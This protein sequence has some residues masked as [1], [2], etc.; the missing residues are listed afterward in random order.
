MKYIIIIITLLALIGCSKEEATTV[1][2]VVDCH[3]GIATMNGGAWDLNGRQV[4]WN[5]IARNNCTNA[6][7]Y[8]RLSSPLPSTKYCKGYQW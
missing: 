7:M 4:E 8:L 3:C 6:P 1:E 5:Y 2:P